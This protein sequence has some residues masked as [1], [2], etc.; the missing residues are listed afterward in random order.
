MNLRQ[1]TFCLMLVLFALIATPASVTRGFAGTWMLDKSRSTGLMPDM[2]QTMD[3][4]HDGDTIIV[5]TRI[6]AKEDNQTINDSYVVDGQE[7]EFVPQ[8]PNGLKGRGVRVIKWLDRGQA[9]EIDEESTFN[10]SQG[11]AGGHITRK[12]SVS[13]DGAT[14]TI[15]S[16][17]K[18]PRGET[19]TKRV[20][21]RKQSD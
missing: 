21:V 17:F 3:V 7:K 16:M 5:E 12:W 10:T 9:F 18:G 20:F 13:E 6:K 19:Q 15:E 8:G 4:V 14:L 1:L 11:P 2:E